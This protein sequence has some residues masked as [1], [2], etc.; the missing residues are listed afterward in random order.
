MALMP[1]LAAA[2]V[3]DTS[4]PPPARL[5][6]LDVA[7]LDR[8]DKIVTSSGRLDGLGAAFG[9]YIRTAGVR[10]AYRLAK[11]ADGDAAAVLVAGETRLR[12]LMAALS[13]PA[14][15]IGVDRDRYTGWIATLAE[16][17]RLPARVAR[18]VSGPVL[19]PVMHRWLEHGRPDPVAAV[20]ETTSAASALATHGLALDPS[21]DALVALLDALHAA[22][23]ADAAVEL[24]GCLRWELLGD[25]SRILA[26]PA[27]VE[28]VLPLLE[29]DVAERL[30]AHRD[31]AADDREVT[32]EQLCE[33]DYGLVRDWLDGDLSLRPAPGQIRQLAAATPVVRQAAADLLTFAAEGALAALPWRDELVGVVAVHR[34]PARERRLPDAVAEF[35]VG[36]LG[37]DPDR[38]RLLT[39]LLEDATA[40]LDLHEL[41][42]AVT[43]LRPDPEPTP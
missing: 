23:L 14:R 6:L 30:R 33:G 31:E 27:L 38:W 34:L 35:L 22:D 15:T 37:G 17:G 28:A 7:D 39:G 26:C 8:L 21:G 36:R 2:L 5:A 19:W 43:A 3:A 16:D 24:A 12:I 11:L 4:L 18:A 20:F 40:D 1:T 29:P 32:F 9:E 10:R 25:D 13:R 41:C 42:A